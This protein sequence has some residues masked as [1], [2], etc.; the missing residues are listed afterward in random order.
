MSAGKDFILSRHMSDSAP[1]Q[2]AGGGSMNVEDHSKRRCMLLAGTIIAAMACLM[3]AVSPA[4]LAGLAPSL[5]LATDAG[6]NEDVYT[7]TMV[8]AMIMLVILAAESLFFSR[9]D[10]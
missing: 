10:E 8:V 9:Y 7:A 6:Y 1:V 2:G 4:A 5:A 3:L